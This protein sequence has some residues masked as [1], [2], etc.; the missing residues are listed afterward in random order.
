MVGKKNDFF[1]ILFFFS[2]NVFHAYLLDKELEEQKKPKGRDF[3][4]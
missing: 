3:S 1:L 4:K 2:K